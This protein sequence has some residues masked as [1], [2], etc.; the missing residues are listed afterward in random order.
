MARPKGNKTYTN[1]ITMSQYLRL[2]DVLEVRERKIKFSKVKSTTFIE[3]HKIHNIRATITILAY[4][5]IKIHQVSQITLKDIREAVN[6]Q[7][8]LNINIGDKG[9]STLLNVFSHFLN[10]YDNTYAIRRFNKPY[11]SLSTDYLQQMVNSFLKE[12]LGD[13]FTSYSFRRNFYKKIILFRGDVPTHT[14]IQQM[15]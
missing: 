10:D 15:R 7:K 11:N 14:T 3:L 6:S 1:K 12:V 4:A 5:G 9:A 13:G 8:L 2:I